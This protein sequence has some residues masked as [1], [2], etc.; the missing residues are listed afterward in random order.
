MLNEV[1]VPTLPS[2]ECRQRGWY[3]RLIK[4][5]MVCAGYEQG[6][7][8]SCSGDSGGPLVWQPGCGQPWQLAGVTS[9][10]ILCARQ[11]KPGVYTRVHLYVD[12]IR[13]H[14]HRTSRPVASELRGQR[15]TS[16]MDVGPFFFTRPNP[17]C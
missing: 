15:G 10:G 16:E 8:D 6:G 11:R 17:R 14:T 12:W 5:D 7:R 4:P 1:V 9:W 2:S 13:Q 3:G